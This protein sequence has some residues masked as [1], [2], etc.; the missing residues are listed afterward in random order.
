MHTE[1]TKPK[2][3]KK[4]PVAPTPP[5]VIEALPPSMKE[6]VKN[7]RA[8]MKRHAGP[9]VAPPDD[10]MDDAIR[11]LAPILHSDEV[12]KHRGILGQLSHAQ[13]RA[14]AWRQKTKGQP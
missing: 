2:P 14:V 8:A 1:R 12:R 6:P 9:P 13:H 5:T 4:A 7:M 3:R 11:A 10:V